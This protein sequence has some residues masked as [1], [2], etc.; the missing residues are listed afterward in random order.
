[1]VLRDV[2]RTQWKKPLTI[3]TKRSITDNWL[4]SWHSFIVCK[5]NFEHVQHINLLFLFLPANFFQSYYVGKYL[6][7]VK[8]KD[9]KRTSMFVVCRIII[10]EFEQYLPVVGWTMLLLFIVDFYRVLHTDKRTSKKCS[11]HFWNL[12]NL[13]FKKVFFWWSREKDAVMFKYNQ[14][15]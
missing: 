6:F 13:F 7:K 5:D 10:C 14:G 1:M 15:Y 11:S 12:R 4:G 8:N 2:F 3:F 9:N